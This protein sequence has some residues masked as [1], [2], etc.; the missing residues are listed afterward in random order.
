MDASKLRN[1]CICGNTRPYLECCGPFAE[2]IPGAVTPNSANGP[3]SLGA[4][5]ANAASP[6]AQASF[7]LV[8]ASG[9][10][11]DALLYHGFRHGL[12]ELSMALFPL[13]A[14][15]QAYWEK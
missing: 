12:H 11:V 3:T 7:G 10:D 4:V 6:S 15:Y 13:R 8:H 2:A 14:L 1:S 5:A 9:T